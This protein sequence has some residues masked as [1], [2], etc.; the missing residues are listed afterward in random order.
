MSAM[1]ET[2]TATEST[3]YR[4][5][6]FFLN[7]LLLNKDEIVASKI[8]EKAGKGFLGKAAAFAANKMISDEKIVSGMAEKLIGGISK[9]I[10][11]LGI[12]ADFKVKY[13]NG[14]FVV[15][16]IEIVEI[17]TLTLILTGKGPEF[18]S[19]FSTLLATVEKLGLGDVVSSKA[20]EKIYGTISE[21]MMTKFAEM[22]PKKMSEQGVEVE[23]TAALQ[24]NQAD[25]FFDILERLNLHQP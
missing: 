25:V 11:E 13:Q 12:E 18:A 3:K 7:L 14:A 15:I 8:T 5:K 1:T 16:R 6:P 21:S 23:C 22:I 2:A 4:C 20:N 24:E 17:D 19:H 10:S 9:T